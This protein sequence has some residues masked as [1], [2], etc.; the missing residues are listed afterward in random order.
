MQDSR[1][2]EYIN[3]DILSSFSLRKSPSMTNVKG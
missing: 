1:E 3:D 2:I